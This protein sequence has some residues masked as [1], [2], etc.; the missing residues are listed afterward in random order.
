MLRSTRCG[1]MVR[2][3]VAWTPRWARGCDHAPS[4]DDRATLR[5]IPATALPAPMK[6]GSVLLRFALNIY[7]GITGFLARRLHRNEKLFEG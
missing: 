1:R 5:A 2:S 3:D 7:R 6:P 4:T